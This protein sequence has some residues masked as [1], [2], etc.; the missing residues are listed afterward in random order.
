M[1][2]GLFAPALLA[3][4]ASAQ[5]PPPAPAKAGGAEVKPPA[6]KPAAGKRG[7]RKPP[8][9]ALPSADVRLRI[10]ARSAEGLWTMRIENEGSHPVRVPADARL[11]ELG[12]ENG[13]T[14]SKKGR[15]KVTCKAPPGL[16][17]DGFP[18]ARALLLAPGEAYV[19]VFDPRLFC[20]GKDAQALTGG[21]IVRAKLGWD[22]PRYTKKLDP[23]FAVESTEVPPTVAP[24]KNLVAPT[25]VLSYLPPSPE[26]MPGVIKIDRDGDGLPD[27]DKDDDKKSDDDKSDDGKKSDKPAIVDEHAPR[28]ELKASPYADAAT[29]YRVSINVTATNVGLRSTL[30]AARGRMVGFRIEGPDG[31]T[32]CGAAHGETRAISRD[33]YRT[34]TPG[35]STSLTVLV[36]EACGRPIFRR[37]GLYRVTPSLRLVESGAELGLAAFTGLVRA[38]EATLVRVH[39]GPAHYHHRPPKAVRPPKPEPEATP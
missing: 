39:A 6:P 36:E 28:F 23:P 34:I 15:R 1:I 8:E 25:M 2:A 29:G 19:E 26:D 35:G 10:L 33:G 17:P 5:E 13:D 31:V 3:A 20:F 12:L 32:R 22:A 7:P 38:K 4:T 11:L 27:A 21:S 14:L 37:P 9:P 18:E 24:E 16:R 30:L